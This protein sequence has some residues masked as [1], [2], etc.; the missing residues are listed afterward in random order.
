MSS[1]PPAYTPPPPLPRPPALHKLALLPPVITSSEAD[2]AAKLPLV[3]EVAA[4]YT[5]TPRLHAHALLGYTL[6]HESEYQAKTRNKE[7]TPSMHALLFSLSE[8]ALQG[9]AADSL[10][11]AAVCDRAQAFISMGKL[12][13]PFFFFF[14]C[15]SFLF[16]QPS[17]PYKLVENLDL[18]FVS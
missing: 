4:A 5:R 12:Y 15:L 3:Q 10:A 17:I 8:D 18:T 9:L 13:T 7:F 6:R 14:F 1:S 2:F 11:A 16:F